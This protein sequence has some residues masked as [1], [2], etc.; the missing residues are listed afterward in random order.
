MLSEEQIKKLVSA[1]ESLQVQLADANAMLAARKEEI[2]FLST[3]LAEST[4]L[5]SKL[6]GQLAEID[7]MQAQIDKKQQAAKGAEERELELHQELTEMAQLNKK[8]SELIQ[9]YAYLQ[10]QYKDILN[11]FT[12]LQQRNAQLEAIAGSMGEL[13]SRLDNSLLERET[14]KEKIN[15]LE[16]QKLIKGI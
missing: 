10:S 1:N 9:D 5:R 3:E 8:Y 12:I 13:Q 6:D 2:D 14:L 15:K 4:A 16:A 11:Q 7:S